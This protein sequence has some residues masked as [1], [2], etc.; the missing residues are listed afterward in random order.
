MECAIPLSVLAKL[1]KYGIKQYKPYN[2]AKKL[3]PE[4]YQLNV[5]EEQELG[6][7]IKIESEEDFLKFFTYFVEELLGRGEVG[8]RITY[9]GV[10]LD[11][12]EK[13]YR[14][15][16]ECEKD[17][18][19]YWERLQTTEKLNRNLEREVEELRKETEALKKENQRLLK[20]V[21]E[22]TEKQKRLELAEKLKK[23]LK[24]TVKL[25]G[26]EKEEVEKLIK[27][28]QEKLK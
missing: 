8:Q 3:L 2:D 7:V 18:S 14:E 5:V 13:L 4:K 10:P 20:E 27:E 11:R 12:Y 21:E 16:L 24:L 25:S 6:K 9:E 15:L 1:G 23:L 28:L 22:L 17:K 26:D 19:L